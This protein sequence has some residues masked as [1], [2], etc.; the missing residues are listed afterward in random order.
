M[1]RIRA[2]WYEYN[3]T[4]QRSYRF[5]TEIGASLFAWWMDFKYDI[6]TRLIYESADTA[7]R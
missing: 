6:K 7:T 2:E 4:Q 1:K 5:F 3:L